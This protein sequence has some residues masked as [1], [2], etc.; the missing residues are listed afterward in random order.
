MR[1]TLVRRASA[2]L[3]ADPQT[4]RWLDFVRRIPRISDERAA[5]LARAHRAGDAHAGEEL[6]AAHLYVVLQVAMKLRVRADSAFD[7]IQEGNA[8]LLDALHRYEPERGVPFSAYSRYWARARMLAYVSSH[9]RL[10]QPGRPTRRR[11]S[12][13]LSEIEHREASGLP[14]DDVSLAEALDLTPEQVGQI[15]EAM[16]YGEAVLDAPEEGNLALVERL[17]DDEMDPEEEIASR[18]VAQ[19]V[20]QAVVSFADTLDK[21][22]DQILFF[23][24]IAS[25]EPASLADLGRRFGVSRERA[26]QLEARILPR[27]REH[28][29]E[30]VGF[31]AVA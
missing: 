26:R 27:F 10:V 13:L 29:R 11:V 16:R 8:G 12:A 20:A 19:R 30:A 17:S 6:V 5:E 4:R 24:R 3:R 22:R 14:T 15:R 28:L 18:Q 2:A 31:D 1:N 25:D 9:S 7:L 23:E 21:E